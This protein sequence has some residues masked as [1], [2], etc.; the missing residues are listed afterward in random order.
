MQHIKDLPSLINPTADTGILSNCGYGTQDGSTISPLETGA[1]NH[2]YWLLGLG[3]H[4][5]PGDSA[6]SVITAILDELNGTHS[7]S[8]NKVF[9]LVPELVPNPD[10]FFAFLQ[11]A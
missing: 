4:L 10:T 5:T 7:F 11:N 8:N 2:H 6:V 9:V 3:Q 1:S